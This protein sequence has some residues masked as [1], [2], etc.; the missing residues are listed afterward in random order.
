MTYPD[1]TP[2]TTVDEFSTEDTYQPGALTL[3]Q[4]DSYATDHHG[5]LSPPR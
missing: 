1:E 4:T 3:S 5:D 2:S